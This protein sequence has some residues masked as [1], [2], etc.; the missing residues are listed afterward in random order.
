MDNGPPAESMT[1]S[2]MDSSVFKKRTPNGACVPPMLSEMNRARIPC[3][4]A[5]C[6]NGLQQTRPPVRILLVLKIKKIRGGGETLSLTTLQVRFNDDGRAP[7]DLESSRVERA[8]GGL[9]SLP[10]RPAPP[11]RPVVHWPWWAR[12]S[13][14]SLFRR[15][16]WSRLWGLLRLLLVADFELSSPSSGL[17]CASF[18]PR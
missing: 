17:S 9:A 13:E 14:A 10:S 11:R 5:G 7:H 2:R 6:A 15:I 18:P 16:S 4:G 3:G 12:R 8:S 1:T